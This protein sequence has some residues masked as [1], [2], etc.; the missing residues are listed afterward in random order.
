MAFSTIQSE[1]KSSITH[2][3]FAKGGASTQNPSQTIIL[4]TPEEAAAIRAK[5]K[6]LKI[7]MLALSLACLV[8]CILLCCLINTANEAAVRIA[9]ISV[10]TVFGW[11]VILLWALGYAPAKADY[12][13]ME[14]VLEGERESC[15]GTLS[16][17]EGVLHIP[18]SIWIRRVTLTDD[19]G[20]THI[21]SVLAD[22]AGSLPPE[23]T[24]VRA[25][26]VR[27]YIVAVEVLH[28]EA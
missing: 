23:G 22:K 24:K 10:S 6:K 4:Y 12:T 25:E 20:N 27:K 1:K 2:K 28:E 15:I 8:I 3:P 14:G 19:N 18:K 13:H 7:L 5:A 9:V 21:L 26:T 17:E 16:L 11:A